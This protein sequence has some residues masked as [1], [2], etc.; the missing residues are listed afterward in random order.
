MCV[1]HRYDDNIDRILFIFDSFI[2]AY[3]SQQSYIGI[4]IYR[5]SCLYKNKILDMRL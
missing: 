3:T 5:K 2:I 4:Y 1:T